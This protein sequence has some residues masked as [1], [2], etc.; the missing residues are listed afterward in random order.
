MIPGVRRVTAALI[1]AE[2][3]HR[4]GDDPHELSIE[5][6]ASALENARVPRVADGVTRALGRAPRDFGEYVRDTAAS[7]VWN[8][9]RG[10]A[11]GDVARTVSM[12]GPA[13]RSRRLPIDH[14]A[15]PGV[16]SGGAAPPASRFQGPIRQLA[17]FGPDGRT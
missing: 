7:G 5:D 6:Y 14:I 15:Q 10:L 3:A 8:V 16:P 11:A 13:C 12:R 2:R 9:G 17:D 1:W 4:S